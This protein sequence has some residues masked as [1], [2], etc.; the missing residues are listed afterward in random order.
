MKERG[1]IK[2]FFFSENKEGWIHRSQV[3]LWHE[4]L[5][6]Q[7]WGGESSFTGGGR[8]TASSVVQPGVDLINGEA[9]NAEVQELIADFNKKMNP[10]IF[11]NIIL[12][13]YR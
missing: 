13:V 3:E 2:I 10:G 8:D 11:R 7:S 6:H 12:P 4:M 1:F 9:T 5:L